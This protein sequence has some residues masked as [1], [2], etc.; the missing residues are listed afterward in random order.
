MPHHQRAHFVVVVA[1]RLLKVLSSAT[2]VALKLTNRVINLINYKIKRD[3]NF[4]QI[5][6]FF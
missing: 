5:L 6:V 1:H 4:S 2:S 3:Q